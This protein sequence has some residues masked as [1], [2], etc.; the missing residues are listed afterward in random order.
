MITLTKDG[1]GAGEDRKKRKS[2]GKG[3]KIKR[4]IRKKG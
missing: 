3:R 1:V 2:R 4:N